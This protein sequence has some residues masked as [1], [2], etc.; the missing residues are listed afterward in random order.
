[1]GSI[2]VT[3]AN[4]VITKPV[5]GDRVCQGDLIET[6][7]DGFVCI[8]F[9]DGTS[10]R[11]YANG[12]MVLEGSSC[13][14]RKSSNSALLRVLKGM[15]G[16]IAGKVVPAGNVIVDTPIAQLKTSASGAAIGSLAFGAL[17]VALIHE[18]KA[19]SAD[20]ALLDDGIIDYKDLKHGIFEIVTKG[21]HPQVIVVD[22]PSETIILRPR[23]T[24]VRV[25]TVANSPAQMAQ[26]QSAYQGVSNVFSQGQ[27]DSFIQQLQQG[28]SP[29]QRADAQPQANPNAQAQT[30]PGT[31]AQTN[32]GTQAQ[33][34][35]SSTS[36][37]SGSST[38][39]STLNINTTS[40]NTGNSQLTQAEN[41]ITS[42]TTTTITV[43]AGGT[44]VTNTNSN[45]GTNNNTGTTGTVT[46][47][48]PQP[49]PAK[50]NIVEWISPSSNNWDTPTA[51]SGS[52]VPGATNAVEILETVNVTLS[53]QA[54]AGTLL[55]GAGAT[56][57]LISGSLTPASGIVTVSGQ[58]NSSG[59][60]FI[61]DAV[62]TIGVGGTI[63]VIGAR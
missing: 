14:A 22:D 45:T 9:A 1:M 60:S 12:R 32:P 46:V 57:A 42:T 16:V 31:Q 11:L 43:N 36:S 23:G 55:I 40:S 63:K 61:S 29:G 38:A 58:L 34:N 15:F 21:D 13:N 10:F 59:T 27:Q 39:P 7:S 20:I 18:L 51:W 50:S 53:T 44:S 56:L 26:L 19:A 4:A 3:R 5:T 52:N 33:A 24:G 49:P 47:A 25:E 41:S 28:I 54:T 8:A 17:T 48:P 2:T 62:I 35:P 37:S 30:T 6:G